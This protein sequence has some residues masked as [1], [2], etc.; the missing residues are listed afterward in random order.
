[1]IGIPTPQ[2]TVTCWAPDTSRLIF[3]PKYGANY[4]PSLGLLSDIASSDAT[5]LGITIYNTPGHTPDSLAFYDHAE[6]HIYV[7]DSFYELSSPKRHDIVY[8]GPIIFPKEGNWIKY[9]QSMNHLLREMRTLNQQRDDG[10]PRVKLSCGHSTVGEDAED[11]LSGILW[12]FH[13]IIDGKVPIISE[14]EIRG[15]VHCLWHADKSKWAVRAPKRLCEE[16]R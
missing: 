13:G 5:D 16:A 15:E 1:L 14:E 8:R 2:Y 12:E 9:L 4:E 11:L 7:G 3:S 10:V 6:R